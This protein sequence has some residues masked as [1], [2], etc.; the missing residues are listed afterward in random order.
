[1]TDQATPPLSGSGG[2]QTDVV[3]INAAP[4]GLVDKPSW[5]LYEYGY[6]V[7]VM[8]ERHTV[9]SFVNGHCALQFAL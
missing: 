3:C 7:H 5:M 9:L 8:E 6:T 1:M 4:V 2:A